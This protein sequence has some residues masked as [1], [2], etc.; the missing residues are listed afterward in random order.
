MPYHFMEH[1]ADVKFQATGESLEKAFSQSAIALKETI[2]GDI[3]VLEQ[4]EKEI[5]IDAKSDLP[6]LLHNFL[7]EFLFLL[8]TEQ[9][10]LSEIKEIS[11]D[12]DTLKLKATLAGDKEENYKFT[13]DVK[14]ITYNDI[15]VELNKEKN[16]WICQAVLDV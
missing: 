14:A 9:F 1:T 7:E 15:K 5:S 4:I 11:I 10:L 16:Q 8:D 12:K 6:E 3:K 2:C 13:N